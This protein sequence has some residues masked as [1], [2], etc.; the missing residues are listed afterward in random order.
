MKK[1][2]KLIVDRSFQMRTTLSIIG[3]VLISISIIISLICVN[4]VLNNNKMSKI[5]N[6]EE[7]TL[8]T[9][10]DLYKSLIM[11]QHQKSWKGLKKITENFSK[12]IIENS[13]I[14]CKNLSVINEMIINNNVFL[15]ILIALVIVQAIVLYMIMIGPTMGPAPA[16]ELK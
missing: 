3:I 7:D 12:N 8:L 15:L 10:T 11:L 16:M 6:S 9:Q 1:R 14:T 2:R 13:S 4:I 5:S